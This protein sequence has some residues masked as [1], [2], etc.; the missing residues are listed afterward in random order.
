ML[1]NLS[2]DWLYTDDLIYCNYVYISLP[3]PSLSLLKKLFFYQNDKIYWCVNSIRG[4]VR[5]ASEWKNQ[6]RREPNLRQAV[7]ATT[8]TWSWF[9]Q[10]VVMGF[11]LKNGFKMWRETY[12]CKIWTDWDITSWYLCE[13]ILMISDYKS[14]LVLLT[15]IYFVI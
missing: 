14:K 13:M 10:L 5:E 11:K 12:C 4:D 1:V 2:H 3:P 7:P 8:L 9:F 6:D 15:V